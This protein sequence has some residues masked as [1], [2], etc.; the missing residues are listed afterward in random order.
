MRDDFYAE[1]EQP[2]RETSMLGFDLFDRYGRLRPEFKTHPIMKGTGVWGR[3]LDHGD[4]LLVEDLFVHQPYRRQ[5]LG[6]KM[7]ETLL[8]LVS[9]KTRSFFAFTWP[10]MLELHDVRLEWDSLQ[11][12]A[13]K[14][15]MSDRESGRAIAF[16]RSLG[17]RRVGSTIWFAMT[18]DLEHPSRKL[19]SLDDFDRPK[20]PT[21]SLHPLLCSLEQI[22]DPPSP[23]FDEVSDSQPRDEPETAP[24]FLSV[25]ENCLQEK[26]ST[27]ICW[28]SQ[29][30]NGNTILHL[31]AATCDVACVEWILKQD[32]GVLL[33][34]SR[35]HHG[36]IPLEMLEFKLE[37][38]RT[39]RTFNLLTVHMSDRFQG[40]SESVVRCLIMLRGF[41]HPEH[42]MKSKGSNAVL[43]IRRGCTCGQCLEGFLSPRMLDALLTQAELGYDMLDSDINDTMGMD[44]VEWHIDC[45]SYLPSKVLNSLKTNKSMRQGFVNVWKHIATCLEKGNAPTQRNV[46]DIVRDDRE[47]P[48]VTKTF[49]ERG[50]SVESAFLA[51]CGNAMEQD[52]VTGDGSYQDT[53]S[54]QIAK[55]PECR[56]DLEFAFVSGACGYR[57][58]SLA[59]NV[60]PW[61]N[62]LDEDGN[63]IDSMM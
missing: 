8:M 20:A 30:K 33:L 44:W 14:E 56:N 47:W 59:R 42:F 19:A 50:G 27:D 39:Q 13:A 41:G 11:D 12:D 4:I 5:R 38:L 43:Q 29:D 53:F 24:D 21:T 28:M 55:L 60:D 2:S 31:A 6:R 22:D 52:E 26:S 9:Q 23:G 45:L 40:Y 61:G 3:E 62:T 34:Q 10:T 54:E 17:F 16:W 32:F 37:R 15:E 49:L 35:N 46:L 18:P 58:I 7:V 36:E 57:R 51:I 63:I 48:P 1:I 25:L